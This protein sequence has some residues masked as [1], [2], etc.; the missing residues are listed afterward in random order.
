MVCLARLVLV[1]ALKVA[2]CSFV[3]G[4]VLGWVINCDSCCRCLGADPLG[5]FLKE[6]FGVVADQVDLTKFLPCGHGVERAGAF[7]SRGD[8]LPSRLLDG[9]SGGRLGGSQGKEVGVANP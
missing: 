4:C 6:R 9:R 2:I 1:D 5:K 8:L 3:D 7:G